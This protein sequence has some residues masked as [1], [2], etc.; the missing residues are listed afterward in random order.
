[1]YST[2]KFT[3]IFEKGV[4][5]SSEIFDITGSGPELS[6]LRNGDNTIQIPENVDLST[7]VAAVRC[8]SM[9]G[10]DCM[11]PSECF[12]TTYDEAQKKCEDIGRRLCTDMEISVC[13]G[14]GC[15]FDS[16]LTWHGK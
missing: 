14:T 12:I 6:I 15:G 16:E 3:S 4:A 8:C 2:F 10:Q 5:N 9:N 11:T 1:M 7:H 13:C